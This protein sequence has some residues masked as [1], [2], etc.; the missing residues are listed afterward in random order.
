[1]ATIKQKRAVDKTLENLGSDSP[2]TMGTILK[3][4]G[5]AD[6]I[7]ENPQIITTSKGFKELLEEALPD[8]LLTE[9]H[10]ELLNSTHLDHMVFPLGPKTNDDKE[11]YIILRTAEAKANKKEYNERDVLSDEEITILLKGVNCITRRFVHGETARHVY[12]WAKD[13]KAVKD[14]LDMAFKLKGSY[15]AEKKDITTGGEKLPSTDLDALAVA[16]AETLKQNKI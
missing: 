5:Y 10:K 3:E 14:A 2:K 15:A 4:S 9:R 8:S 13:N 7:A 16:M 11:A 1:M 6:T 12:F